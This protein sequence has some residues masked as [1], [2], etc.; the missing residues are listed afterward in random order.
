ML[1]RRFGAGKILI[2]AQKRIR[3]QLEKLGPI[4]AQ[5]TWAHHGAVTGRDEWSDVRA[6]IV[7][8]RSLPSPAAVDA[9]AEALT[10]QPVAE[11]SGW[12]SAV[13]G[14]RE[15]A[16]GSVTAAETERHPHPIAEAFRWRACEGELQQIIERARGVTRRSDAERVDVVVVTDVPL[17]LP[18]D[19]LS[20]TDIAPRI[21]DQMLAREGLVL[22]SATD[23]AKAFKWIG[24]AGRVRQQRRRER[25]RHGTEWT[26]PPGLLSRRYRRAETGSHTELVL[27]DPEL[28]P[29]PE[30]LLQGVLGSLDYL[31]GPRPAL[32]DTAL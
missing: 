4:P 12:Y 14:T 11:R 28:V 8:G 16:D 24:T 7:I 5:V 23:S 9:Q 19:T 32:C 31:T 26:P 21:E 27:Y 22:L 29:H 17:P 20:E 1:A 3:K 13:D 6:M 30:V 18:V 10:G 15:L 2:V 25:E